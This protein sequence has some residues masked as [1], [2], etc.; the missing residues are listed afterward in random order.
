MSISF[1][2]RKFVSL[3]TCLSNKNKHVTKRVVF[4]DDSNFKYVGRI[5]F[6]KCRGHG[7]LLT[8]IDFKDF[9][10]QQHRLYPL[11]L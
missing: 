11:D 3:I 10:F 4:I 6:S 8:S 9:E 1:L 7:I 5:T 2:R